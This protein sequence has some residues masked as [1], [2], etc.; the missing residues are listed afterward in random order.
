MLNLAIHIVTT[1]IQR[2]NVCREVICATSTTAL[3]NIFLFEDETR[4]IYQKK[5][6]YIYVYTHNILV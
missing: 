2:V 6:L 4:L 5:H 3:S 1:R